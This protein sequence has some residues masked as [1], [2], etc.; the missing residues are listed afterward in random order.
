MTVETA[1]HIGYGHAEYERLVDDVEA[2][3]ALPTNGQRALRPVAEDFL[4]AEAEL[5]DSARFEDW[6]ALFTPDSAYWVAA[7]TDVRDP[8]THTGLAFDDR[9]RLDDRVYWLRT[10]LAYCQIPESRTRHVIGNVVARRGDE[11]GTLLVRSNFVLTE[12]RADMTRSFSGWYGHVLT[13]D[14]AADI[15]SASFAI[16]SKVVC[17]VEADAGHRNLTI[18][19]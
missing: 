5:I 19:F 2:L 9:R 10:G 12:N 8:R 11:P 18:I 4:F 6:L 7:D 13:H 16:R 3:K 17:L 15:E 14:P 1:V